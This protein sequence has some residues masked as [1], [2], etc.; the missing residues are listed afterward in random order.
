MDYLLNRIEKGWYYDL[1]R[2]SY[3]FEC[4]KRSVERM[5]CDL[6]EEGYDIKYCRTKNKYF[7]EKL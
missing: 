4:C 1:S 3:R 5:I 2:V 6:R 7:L